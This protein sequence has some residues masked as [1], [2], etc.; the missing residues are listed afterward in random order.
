MRLGR[1]LLTFYQ[2]FPYPMMCCFC[3]CYCYCCTAA[4]LVCVCLARD[5]E[6]HSHFLVNSLFHIFL[7]LYMHGGSCRTLRRSYVCSLESGDILYRI[8]EYLIANDR[9]LWL[10]SVCKGWRIHWKS[11]RKHAGTNDDDDDDDDVQLPHTIGMC[12][13]HI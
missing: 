12:I 3:C 1:T 2:S 4:L 5:I 9:E 6:Q 10:Q 11:D 8:C 7:S 13:V